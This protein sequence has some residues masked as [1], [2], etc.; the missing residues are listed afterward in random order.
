[1]NGQVKFE[2]TVLKLVELGAKVFSVVYA[3]KSFKVE[4][5]VDLEKE[6]VKVEWKH[7]KLGVTKSLDF[8]LDE[9]AGRVA[10]L[11]EELLASGFTL[12]KGSP[13]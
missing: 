7:P 12:E 3:K 4:V 11:L 10:G 2:D 8:S 13:G 5:T 1:M 9:F 6:E